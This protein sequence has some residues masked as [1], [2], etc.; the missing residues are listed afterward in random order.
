MELDLSLEASRLQT[1]PDIVQDRKRLAR[2]GFSYNENEGTLDC[3][4]CQA[5][6]EGSHSQD[7]IFLFAGPSRSKKYKAF[8]GLFY[9]KARL[10]TF[11]DWPL[12]WLS[13]R[14]L[15]ADGLY[16]LRKL[17]YCACAFCNGIIGAWEKRD[18]PRDEHLRHFG[19]C[20][21]VNGKPVGNVPLSQGA[22]LDRLCMEGEEPPLAPSVR[23]VP[24]EVSLC[25]SWSSLHLG[26]YSSSETVKHTKICI[27]FAKSNES[28]SYI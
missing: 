15:A 20:D 7:C 9:E 2:V 8:T 25:W 12:P 18:N 23:S 4:G 27:Y 16:Y 17:D 24:L 13:P 6:D 5:K 14:D 10:E 22:I 21:F 26:K 3:F 28:N 19:H 11:I 1:Y